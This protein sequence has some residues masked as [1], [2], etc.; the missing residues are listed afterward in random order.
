LMNASYYQNET[1]TSMIF[2][3]KFVEENE[4]TILL[5]GDNYFL[6]AIGKDNSFG[7][8]PERG[9]IKLDFSNTDGTVSIGAGSG[10]PSKAWWIVHGVAMAVSW[11]ILVPFAVSASILKSYL[12]AMPAGFW[13]RTHRNLN[14]WAVIL[15]T[16]GFA[17]SVYLTADQK[18][19]HFTTS[20]HHKVGLVVFLFSFLQALSGFFRPSLPHKPDPVVD[21]DDDDVDVDVDVD[22][23]DTEQAAAKQAKPNVVDHPLQKSPQRIF[24]EYQHRILGAITMVLGWYNCE[25][26]FDAYNRL[27]DGPE[28]NGALWA[29]VGTITFFTVILAVYDR[30]VRQRD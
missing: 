24:F 14:A 12:S 7:I 17:I 5:K 13:Y 11:V 3:K 26:G 1:H 28:L 16:F 4:Q 29:V 6:W 2:T 19:K 27:F 10:P 18:V 9:D 30:T 21:D 15:T 22:N 23:D 25:S 8:H 20:T